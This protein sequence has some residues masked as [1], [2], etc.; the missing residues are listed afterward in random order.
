MPLWVHVQPENKLIALA[1][2]HDTAVVEASVG[3]AAVNRLNGT[4]ILGSSITGKAD[5]GHTLG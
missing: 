1:T 3:A 2:Y 5:C 4:L